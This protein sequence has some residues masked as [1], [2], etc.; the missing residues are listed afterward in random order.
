M[1]GIEF[2]ASD[3]QAARTKFLA[4]AKACGASIASLDHPD[5]G[6]DGRPLF[7]D[8]ALLGSPVADR[9]LVINSAT[10]G[11]EGFCGSAA[12]VGWLSTA[13]RTE[14]PDDVRLVLVH[15]IN[16]HGFAWLRRETED[17]VDLNRNFRNFSG[18]VPQNEAYA[19]L[20]P[21]ITPAHWDESVS[22]AVFEIIDEY[23]QKHGNKGLQDALQHGQYTHPDGIFFGGS[24]PTW[25]NRTIRAIL[26]EYVAGARHV[27]LIDFHT[28][29]GPY[30]TAELIAFGGRASADRAKTWYQNG[31]VPVGTEDSISAKIVGTLD[32]A[33]SEGLPE[34]SLTSI[35]AE[36]GTYPV[37][38]IM[39]ALVASNWLYR[40]GD[41]ESAAG[42][43]IVSELRKCFYPDEDDWKDLVWVRA[44]Q[45]IRRAV[46]HLQIAA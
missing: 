37:D 7:T 42:K 29:L 22:R 33:F 2:S 14:I 6:P 18:P 40:K 1:D 21:K 20:H 8:V 15:A 27:G 36:Y 34:A 30:G 26:R 13:G 16:P 43:A 41:C 35:S 45:I 31:V 4:A 25:S 5:G 44:R 3:Y 24:K 19:A 9:V 39:K 23:R 28:G 12:Q 32:L 17:N 46:H 10:H 38:R 11:V